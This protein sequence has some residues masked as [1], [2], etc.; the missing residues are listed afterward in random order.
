[1][2][3]FEGTAARVLVVIPARYGSTRFPGKA[4]AD[5]G[6]RPLVVRVAENARGIRGAGKVIV[7]TDDRRIASA[8]RDAGLACEMTGEHPTGTDRVGEVA[9]RHEAEIILNLQGDEP[10]LDPR[11]VDHLIEAML[12]DPTCDIGTCAHPFADRRQWEDPNA[13]KVV[14]DH[15]GRALYFSRAP[16]PGT[17]PGGTIF[18]HE[19]AQRHVGIYAYRRPALERFLA[20]TATPLEGCEGLEQLRALENGMRIKVI[21]ID[22]AP[23]GVDTPEDLE[24]ARRLWL[25]R[26]GEEE[27]R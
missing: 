21:G 9:G 7:A 5:L 20:L 6:G 12:D 17:F 1:V 25:A 19:I 2:N 14:V 16:I 22:Q 4:L 11:D 8:V 24:R 10:L 3:Q 26:H 23:V 18:G 13:V 27:N 15:R